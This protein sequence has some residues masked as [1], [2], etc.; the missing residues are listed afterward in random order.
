[1]YIIFILYLLFITITIYVKN[2]NMDKY[3]NNSLYKKIVVPN[4]NTIEEYNE[5]M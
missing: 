4:F 5:F 2:I 1:M 3:E